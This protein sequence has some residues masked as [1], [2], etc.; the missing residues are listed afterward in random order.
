MP[1]SS[2]AFAPGRGIPAQ[3]LLFINRHIDLKCSERASALKAPSG[4]P[5]F[6]SMKAT[7]H[8][9]RFLPNLYSQGGRK[10]REDWALVRVRQPLEVI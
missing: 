10:G 5:A 8:K 4:C 9:L 2:E 7:A 1:A 3:Y 6:V